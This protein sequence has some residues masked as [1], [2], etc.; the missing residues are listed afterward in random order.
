MKARILPTPVVQY[1]P[2]SRESKIT[3]RDG[4]WNLKDKRVAAGATLG[5]WVVVSFKNEKEL[6]E[7][8]INNFMRELVATCQD[9]G[10]VSLKDIK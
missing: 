1:H 3:P 2:S 5:S 6:P 4:A 7:Q 10:M 8:L 9:T